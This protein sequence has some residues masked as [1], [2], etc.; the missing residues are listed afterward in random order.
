MRDDSE[1]TWQSHAS[2][3]LHDEVSGRYETHHGL[4]NGF[5]INTGLGQGCVNA[6][7]RSKLP[8]VLIQR[9][10]VR[11]VKGFKFDGYDEHGGVPECGSTECKHLTSDLHNGIMN[12]ISEQSGSG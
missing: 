10:I 11:L 8:L 2:C 12:C 6:A 1:W 7:E 4:T 5:G 3:A 9:T